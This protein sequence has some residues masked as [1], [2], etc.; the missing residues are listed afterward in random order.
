MITRVKVE[1]IRVLRRKELI[2]SG[3][4]SIFFVGRNGSGKTTLLEAIAFPGYGF[5]YG[6]SAAQFISRGEKKA[7]IEI[8]FSSEGVYH[9][10]RSEIDF[11][12]TRLFIDGKQASRKMVRS[13]LPLV[14]YFP[15]DIYLVLG[16]SEERRNYIDRICKQVIPGYSEL[17]ADYRTSIKQRQALLRTVSDIHSNLQLDIIEE[18]M[19]EL[20]VS[21]V[22]KRLMIIDE[23]NQFFNSSL[24]GFV[25]KR[26]NIF[27]RHSSKNSTPS[28][29][30]L[31]E[32]LYV[33]RGTDQKFE[34]TSY[35][36][37]RDGIDLIFESRNSRYSSS[38]GE[39]KIIALALKLGE[40]KIIERRTG[41]N[42]IFMADDLFSELD[43][44]KKS[45][46]L[47]YLKTEIPYFFA[48]ATELPG[49][50][51]MFKDC[52]IIYMS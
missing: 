3:E 44:E 39:R 43:N 46:V 28:A 50:E 37:H 8:E 13:K 2:L 9:T 48:T 20:A 21:I 34:K 24:P 40:R 6:V 18:K 16:G 19:A 1:N 35:G 26:V 12:A 30:T 45:A 32:L 51:K 23:L 33:S 10:I 22:K 42:V 25:A 15:Q 47:E 49:D 38:F 4:K 27:Y 29:D 7:S 17:I 11:T 31:Q 5:L 36:P 14:W 52:E 41:R